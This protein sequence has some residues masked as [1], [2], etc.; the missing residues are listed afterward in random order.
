M[1]S[2]YVANARVPTLVFSTSQLASRHV[3]VMIKNLISENNSAGQP[4]VL[5][6]PT[7]ST[8]LGIYREL[9]RMHKEEGLDFARVITFNLD[10]YMGLA[11][12]D[13]HSYR[14]WMQETFF[15]HVNLRP[16]NIHIPDGM[17]S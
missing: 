7:G 12:D 13:A 4:T 1:S 15:K 5:G 10:E 16:E 14:R 3:A 9:I 6:L 11:H 2:S 17:I 8:P